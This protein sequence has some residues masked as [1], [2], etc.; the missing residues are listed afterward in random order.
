MKKITV[1]S[2]WKEKINIY[3]QL[4]FIG[5]NLYIYMGVIYRESRGRGDIKENNNNNNNNNKEKETNTK[6]KN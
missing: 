5:G 2:N 3:I 4:L 6:L 1:K